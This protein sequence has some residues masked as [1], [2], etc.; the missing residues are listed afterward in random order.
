MTRALV[1]GSGG[2]T[3]IAWEAG[4]LNGLADSG[5]PVGDWNL[6]VGSSAET[7]LQGTSGSAAGSVR[8]VRSRRGL[9]L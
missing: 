2:L 1:L 4:V 3:G 6:V 8:S 7:T 9:P 5:F